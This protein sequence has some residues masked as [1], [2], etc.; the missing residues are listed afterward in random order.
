MRNEETRCVSALVINLCVLGR[1]RS[2]P[3]GRTWCPGIISLP[4]ATNALGSH[5]C[6]RK[7]VQIAPSRVVCRAGVQGYDVRALRSPVIPCCLS[8]SSGGDSAED[9]HRRRWESVSQ[10]TLPLLVFRQSVVRMGGDL[11]TSIFIARY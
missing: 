5:C 6:V 7:H 1:L 9:R 2:R 11:I 10:N 8:S 3:E 4:A